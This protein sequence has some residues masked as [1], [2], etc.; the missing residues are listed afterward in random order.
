MARY[1]GPSC[2]LCRR[3]GIKLYLKGDRCYTER[4]AIDRRGYAP[5]Q[6]GQARRKLSEYG[7]QLREKQKA[8]RIYGVLERQFKRYF[9]IAERKKGVTGENLLRILESRLDNVVYRMGF[10]SSRAEARQLI[11]HGHFTVNGKKVNIPSYLVRIGEVIAVKE[12]SRKLSRIKELAE[13][14]AQRN[15]PQWLEVN[16][17]AMEGRVVGLPAREDIDV[18]IEE[19]LIVELYSK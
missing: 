4:C 19:H 7:I 18:P 14:A 1:I 6:H 12:D 11:R 10:A 8:K 16:A 17:E 3:E 2:R 9:E 5:G 13:T 15:V